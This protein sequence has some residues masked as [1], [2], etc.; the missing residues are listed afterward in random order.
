MTADYAL[1]DSKM[2][3]IIPFKFGL[4]NLLF[5]SSCIIVLMLMENC[6]FVFSMSIIIENYNLSVIVKIRL[7]FN[8]IIQDIT[9]KWW[10]V[11]LF[12]KEF[13]KSQQ[14][15]CCCLRKLFL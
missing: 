13:S 14:V 15:C 8:V 5:V 10:L 9:R 6:G 3:L 11:R 4:K 7:I 2:Q 1:F 12:R